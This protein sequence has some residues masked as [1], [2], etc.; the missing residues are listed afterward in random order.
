MKGTLK[1]LSALIITVA[2]FGTLECFFSFAGESQQ[3]VAMLSSYTSPVQSWQPAPRELRLHMMAVLGLRNTG[4]LERLKEQLQRPDS[5]SYHRWL[6]RAEF[7]YQFGPTAAQLHEVTS[8]LNAHDFTVNSADLGTREVRFSGSVA[9]AEQ[10]FDTTIVRD[11]AKFA[12]LGIP[13]VP[14]DLAGAIVAIFGLYNLPPNPKPLPKE[15]GII[16]PLAPVPGSNKLHFSPQDFWLFYNEPPPTNSGAN[17]GTLAPDCIALLENATLPAV[18]SSASSPTPSVVDIFTRQFKIPPAKVTIVATDPNVQPQ[19][20]TDN[21]PPLDVDWA[22]SVAPNTPIRIY[23]AT[24]PNSLSPA[25][26]TLSLAVSQNVCG[27]ISSSID[28]EREGCPDLAQ[29][30]AYAETDAQAVVQGQTLFIPPATMA[31]SI[32]ADSRAVH[33]ARR[34]CSRA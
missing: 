17:G 19:Q 27:V 14:A 25:F 23:V 18:P 16:S 34:E 2:V 15:T 5:P 12:N 8:W 1:H 7:A 31:L 3:R 9:Q 24:S 28:D 10:A 21:E 22:H 20:P 6:S 4:E 32:P 30:Q 33:P 13:Q 26:D 11:G 29:I